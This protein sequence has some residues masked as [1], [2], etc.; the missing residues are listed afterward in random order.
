M[1]LDRSWWYSSCVD[2]VNYFSS[3]EFT[4]SDEGFQESLDAIDS[5]IKEDGP[6]DGILGFSQGGAMAAI[7]AA[8]T[9]CK[10][11]GT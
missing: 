8:T 7:V 1:S 11:H 2:G 9:K 5:K 6:F 3:K 10:N 4:D